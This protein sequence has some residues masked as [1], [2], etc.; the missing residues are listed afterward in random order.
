M[1]S[2]KPFRSPDEALRNLF[3]TQIRILRRRE[4]S[5]GSINRTSILELSNGERV[6]LKENGMEYGDMFAKEARGLAALRVTGGPR[7]PEALAFGRNDREQFLLLEY[8]ASGNKRSDFLEDFG[9]RL[10]HLHLNHGKHFGFDEDNFIGSTV[11]INTREDRWTTFFGKHRLLFQ[12]ALAVKNHL[13]EISVFDRIEKLALGLEAYFR[14]DT[15]PSILHGDL[16]AGN[17]MCDGSGTCVIFDPAVY[18]GDGEADLAMTE[19]FGRLDE[20]F[21]KAYGEII[22]PEPGYEDR[23]E[24]YNLYHLLN[25]L[26]LF[27]ESYL[28]R[29]MSTLSRFQ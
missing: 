20:K 16:W 22:P 3:G 5:G 10:A 29:V 26:N 14:K 9:R 18:Y 2:E 24:I 15:A 7:I 1:R 8:I 17:I 4:S 12:A 27:G 23:R 19:L 11:Q 21:Y 28:G 13:L 6:F 25:H